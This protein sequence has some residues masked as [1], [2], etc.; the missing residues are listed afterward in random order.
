MYGCLV[1]KWAVGTMHVADLQQTHLAGVVRSRRCGVV[2]LAVDQ[3]MSLSFSD[4]RCC[5][6][7]R[8]IATRIAR[9]KK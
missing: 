1:E 8:L 3:I 5:A 4:S 9:R 7:S 6:A 2:V